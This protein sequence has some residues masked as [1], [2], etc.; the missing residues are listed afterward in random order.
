MVQKLALWIECC[1]HKWTV[2]EHWAHNHHRA[3]HR[4]HSGAHVSYLAMVFFHGPYSYAAGFLLI[5][6][7]A[8]WLLHLEDA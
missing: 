2:V 5:I 3:I 7:I 6:I 8:M 1:R 4:T